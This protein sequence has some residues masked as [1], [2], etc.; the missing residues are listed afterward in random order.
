MPLINHHPINENMVDPESLLTAPT[1]D[2]FEMGAKF[3]KQLS[4]DY[5]Y[6]V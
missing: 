3:C 6:R 1:N 2:T 5:I 4:Y